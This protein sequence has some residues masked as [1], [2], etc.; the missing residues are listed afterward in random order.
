MKPIATKWTQKNVSTL[1]YQNFYVKSSQIFL[2]ENKST[3]MG[4]NWCLS[5]WKNDKKDRKN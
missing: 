2:K 3:Q 4:Q 5:I 1:L